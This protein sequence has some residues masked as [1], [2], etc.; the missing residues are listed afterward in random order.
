MEFPK[1]FIRASEAY[2]TFEHHVPAPYLRRAFQA[3]H[4]AKANVIITALGFYELYLNGERITKGR[5][6]PYINNPDDLV[7]YDTYE[8][9]LR[10][11]ENVLGV[12]LGNGFTNNPGGHIWDFD[13][14]AF[15]AAPQMA[16]CLT[17]TDKS[18][19]AHCIESDET[20]R[21]ESSPLLFDDYRF[22]EIYDGRLEIPGWNTIGFD[23]SAWKF[24]ERAPQPRG[25]KRLCTAEPIDIVNELKPISVT[26]T[27]K[28]YLY[29]FGINTAGVC[30][31]C[32]RGELDQR[33]ELRH[34]EHLKDGLPDVENIWFKREHWARDLEY[35]HKDVYTCRGDGEEVYTPA[36]TYHG[37]RY[38]LVSGITEAQATEDLL[39]ALEMHS[40]LEERGGFSCSD[41]TANKLQQMTRQ[42]DVTNFYYFPTDC[43]QREKNGWTADAALSSEHI[44]LNLGA[45]K[46]YREWLRAIVKAQDNNGALPGIVPTSGWGFAWGNG[47]AWDSVLIELP[48]RLYQYRG[49]LDSA[50]T[51][52]PGDHQIPALPHNAYGRARPARHRP[53]RL[54][55]AG[56]RS[57]RI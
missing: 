50:K 44:L 54:V 4:E 41:E 16:L 55:P 43:P 45:E 24:A 9:T 57:A 42:S 18:G 11:G 53:W 47:P 23:D 33:I 35:V 14:A 37:F 7:Y 27:E 28:G 6:A 29:D 38:V 17:Y 8:V 10:A 20:W 3:D 13:I 34:G 22:G 2:N 5:L 46:S 19:E 15:R 25:E 48:Y 26:K 49:D 31:L 40:L 32:V 36:F 30:R 56:T 52:R 1:S 21:T 51:V 12:W 39:T